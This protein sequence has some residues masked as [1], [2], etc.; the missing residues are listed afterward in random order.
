MHRYRLNLHEYEDHR[1]DE[2]Y[3]AVYLADKYNLFKENHSP[4]YIRGTAPADAPDRQKVF[5]RFADI[6]VEVNGLF[7]SRDFLD[8]KRQVDVKMLFTPPFGFPLFELLVGTF[9]ATEG[10]AKIICGQSN[11]WMY[12][13]NKGVRTIRIGLGPQFK[14]THDTCMRIIAGKV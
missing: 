12:T 11:D 8:D 1:I 7:W 13:L 10:T 2:W 14:M 6:S 9:K 5:L 4:L 3:A